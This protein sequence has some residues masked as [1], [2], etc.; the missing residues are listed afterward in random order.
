MEQK[1]VKS[2][3]WTFNLGQ[4]LVIITILYGIIIYLMDGRIT[5]QQTYAQQHVDELIRVNEGQDKRIN[6]LDFYREQGIDFSKA[7]AELFG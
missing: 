5:R 7:H 6:N 1:R 3:F 2:S 4:L